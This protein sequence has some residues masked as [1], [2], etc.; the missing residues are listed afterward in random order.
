MCHP[1]AFG[2]RGY[3]Q[4]H[5]V[6]CLGRC[7]LHEWRWSCRRWRGH[8]HLKHWQA[9]AGRRRGLY[10]VITRRG[11]HFGRSMRL[12]L[13]AD[14]FSV[15]LAGRRRAM[16]EET[17][18]GT[19]RRQPRRGDRGA[20]R[21]YG[22]RNS[23]VRIVLSTAKATYGPLYLLFNNA[24][25]STRNILIEDL[26]LEQWS[27]VVWVNLTCSFPCAQHA[28]R[29]M[30]YQTPRGGRPIN[31]GSCLGACSVGES[32]LY[33][34]TQARADWTDAMSLL[35]G[36]ARIRYRV[37][38]DRGRQRRDNAQRRC[39]RRGRAGQRQRS[40]AEVRIHVNDV[41]RG[42]AYMASLSLEAN[43]QFMTV[44]ATKMPYIG[45]RLMMAGTCVLR[46]ADRSFSP[47]K[48]LPYRS[49]HKSLKPSSLVMA[50]LEPVCSIGLLT[51]TVSL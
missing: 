2:C 34:A 1:D 25:T 46:A 21:R 31:N 7:R 6:P 26:T 43:V 5:C 8:C 51:G 28:F 13:F 32:D 16:L 15:V 39:R 14:G 45:P 50:G 11:L 42:V 49:T 9:A 10:R 44:M 33:V 22:T 17:G 23:F 12:A 38:A 4:G 29:M 24:G 37:W 20:D 30:K 47:G 40:K 35:L 48:V 27:N 3:P 36:W 41:A 18:R 19:R